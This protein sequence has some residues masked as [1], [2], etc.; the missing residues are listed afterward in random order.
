MIISSLVFS[1]AISLQIKGQIEQEYDL[2]KLNALI[3]HVPINITSNADFG[4]YAIISGDGSPGTPYLIDNLNITTTDEF[5][6]SISDVSVYFIIQNCFIKAENPVKISSTIGINSTVI[7]NTF[8]PI[9]GGKGLY[10]NYTAQV[11]IIGNNFT[12]GSAGIWI[13]T[14]ITLQRLSML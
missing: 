11:D 4:N 6:I 9:G 3:N 5:G 10:L 7:S 1:I 14:A 2:V 12:S 13:F 8:D